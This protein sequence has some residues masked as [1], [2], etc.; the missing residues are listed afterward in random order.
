MEFVCFVWI[1]EQTANF[2]LCS[3][4]RLVSM[5]EVESVYCA[6]RTVLIYHKHE[7]SNLLL[8]TADKTEVQVTRK[9]LAQF[10]SEHSAVPHTHMHFPLSH[11]ARVNTTYKRAH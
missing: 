5:I 7:S 9:W 2:V 1:S 11:A 4:K 3:I 10:R 6:V 8:I